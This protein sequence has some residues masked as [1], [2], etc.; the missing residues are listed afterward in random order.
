MMNSSELL[1]WAN[2]PLLPLGRQA[3][4]LREAAFG[5]HAY[6]SAQPAPALVLTVSSS[7]S[8]E[9]IVAQLLAARAADPGSVEPRVLAATGHTTGELEI[10]LIALARLVFPAPVHIRANWTRL[11]D[12][13]A[14]VALRFGAD[15][16]S[17]LPPD[18]DHREILRVIQEAGRLPV[19]CDSAYQAVPLPQP[20]PSLRVLPA[21]K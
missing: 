21:P 12:A 16:L 5:D 4:S 1:T 19:H 17:D 3:N 7:D 11:S 8:P 13:V 9:E 14:Q 18:L 6:F 10:R 2:Q 15:E 20:P